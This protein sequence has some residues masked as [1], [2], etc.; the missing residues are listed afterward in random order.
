M[1]DRIF[2][3]GVD[4]WA[5][6]R[7]W[8]NGKLLKEYKSLRD[9]SY[10]S[11]LQNELAQ[12]LSGEDSKVIDQIWAK[13]NGTMQVKNVSNSRS[14]SEL[15]VETSSAYD[16]PG[17]YTALFSGNSALG[18]G[19]YYNSIACN[20]V[21]TAGS[22]LDFTIKWTF[23]GGDTNGQYVCASRL[24]DIGDNYD[25]PIATLDV[26]SDKAACVVS[27][28]NN[29]VTAI[30]SS[31]P[32]AGP[33]TITILGFDLDTSA[34]AFADWSQFTIEVASGQDFYA[35]GEFVIG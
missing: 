4:E 12:L 26:V 28:S 19:S 16:I 31:D 11:T 29:T 13:V 32:I 27:A 22:E 20:I 18:S 10:T 7:V 24:G 15:S 33:T 25:H 8:E 2:K 1:L 34:V 35:K 17:T 21:L 6:A 5:E 30:N 3:I 9:N 23:S 14:A